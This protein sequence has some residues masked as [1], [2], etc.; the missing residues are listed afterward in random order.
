[1]QA[2]GSPSLTSAA[3][4]HTQ[5]RSEP[6]LG[7]SFISGTTERQA[8]ISIT[9]PTPLSPSKFH[10]GNLQHK[11]QRTVVVGADLKGL[12]TTHDQTG[13]A[14]LLVL[15]QADVTGTALLPLLGIL[16]EDEELGAHLEELLFGLLVGLGLDLLGQADHGLEVD[17]IGLGSF[18]L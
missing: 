2:S 17:I 18:L 15:E 7:D 12:V 4:F 10:H 8:R 3:A 16:L 1:M 13:L 11:I 6:T 5:D 14:V 9:S